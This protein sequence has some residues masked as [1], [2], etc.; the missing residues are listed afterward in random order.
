MNM[1]ESVGLMY[2]PLSTRTLTPLTKRI[3]LAQILAIICGI[4][5]VLLKK[6]MMMTMHP[7]T[8]VAIAVQAKIV[9]V[10]KTADNLDAGGW[11][12]RLFIVNARS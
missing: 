8:A 3:D 6:D 2:E 1:K 10:R 4:F 7:S 9:A 5:P 11:E 12:L